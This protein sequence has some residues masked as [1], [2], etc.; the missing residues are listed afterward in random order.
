[1]QQRFGSVVQPSE[2]QIL[3]YYRS[4]REQFSA[5]GELRP[6]GEVHDDIRLTLATERRA[7]A[8]REWLTNL[9]RRANVNVLYRS[10]PS[11]QGAGTTIRR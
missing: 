8:I 2:E 10:A 11:G 9:R 7:G 1:L 5:G 4:H 3:D 6:Y